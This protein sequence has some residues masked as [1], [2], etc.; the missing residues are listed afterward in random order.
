M[1]G[2]LVSLQSHCVTNDVGLTMNLPDVVYDPVG[3]VQK[4]LKVIAW[5]GRIIIVGFAAGTIEKI[6]MNLVLLK[7]I[8]IVG[9]HWGMYYSERSEHSPNGTPSDRHSMF[10]A[11]IEHEPE[12][13]DEVWEVLM[14]LFE[15]GKL[16]PVVYNEVFPSVDDTRLTP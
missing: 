15:S 1:A 12:H 5:K 9:L 8:A 14:A 10:V 11:D 4:S 3:L 6:P 2:V 7:N 13:P 16:K